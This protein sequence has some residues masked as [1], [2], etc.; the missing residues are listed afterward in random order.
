MSI[1]TLQ[2]NIY[3]KAI[4]EIL[5]TISGILAFYNK[6]ADLNDGLNFP[7]FRWIEGGFRGI[8]EDVYTFS[9]IMATASRLTVNSICSFDSA[10]ASGG[11]SPNDLRNYWTYDHEILPDVELS[12]EARNQKKKLTQLDWSVNYRPK[13]RK[14]RFL[15]CNI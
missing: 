12:E 8:P 6:I 2:S 9:D 14:S 5:E 1:F 3:I 15:N 7:F 4:W 13:Y 11:G 10:I